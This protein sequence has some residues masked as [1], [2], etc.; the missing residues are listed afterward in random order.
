MDERSRRLLQKTTL[1]G[2]LVK[3]LQMT[4]CLQSDLL[5]ILIYM[6]TFMVKTK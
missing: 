1:K 2:E 6:Y 3:K 5:N 4:E